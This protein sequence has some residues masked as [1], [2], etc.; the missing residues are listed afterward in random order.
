D[1]SEGQVTWSGQPPGPELMLRQS[2][3]FQRPVLMRRSVAA[4]LDFILRAR[5]RPSPEK[6][7][8]AL[9]QVGLLPLSAEPARR[10]SGGEQQRL[11]LARALLTDPDVLFLDEP[12]ANL[13]PTATSLIESIVRQSAKTGTKVIFV[14]HDPGQARRLAE[15]VVFLNRGKIACH[16]DAATF[17]DAPGDEAARAYLAGELTL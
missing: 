13:D 5:G 3:V 9:D 15:D 11:A 1:P 12:T 14:T 6:R 2:M 7:A 4:N 8:A 17:F 10:L 16:Q